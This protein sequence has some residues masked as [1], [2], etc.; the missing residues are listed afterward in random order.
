[1]VRINICGMGTMGLKAIK[2]HH[3]TFWGTTRKWKEKFKSVFISVQLSEMHVAERVNVKS[4]IILVWVWVCYSA[5]H[6]VWACYSATHGVS[7]LLLSFK[8][9]LKSLLLDQ[10]FLLL[11]CY[12]LFFSYLVTHDLTWLR[13]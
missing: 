7:F 4:H 2:G 12:F 10:Y 13:L 5:T 9:F 6:G 11:Y 1:M 3:K 8:T